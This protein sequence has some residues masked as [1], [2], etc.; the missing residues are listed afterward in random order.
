MFINL[1]LDFYTRNLYLTKLQQKRV[2]EREKTWN[3][4]PPVYKHKV[5]VSWR[6]N[7]LFHCKLPKNCIFNVFLSFII[8]EQSPY[9]YG[10]IFG[11]KSKI[12]NIIFWLEMTPTPFRNFS[13]NWSVLV[14]WPFPKA[15]SFKNVIII[16]ST[17]VALNCQIEC[18][19]VRFIL[20]Q[21]AL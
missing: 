11:K 19:I 17:C 6:L 4:N 2:F 15:L 7:F 21:R 13:E 5:H 16:W 18:C 9:Q 10:W 12:C 1:A 14:G 20:T 3:R 8:R